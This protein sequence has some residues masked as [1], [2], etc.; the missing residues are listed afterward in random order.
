MP[1]NKNTCDDEPPKKKRKL[2]NDFKYFGESISHT[3]FKDTGWFGS[4]LLYNNFKYN[5]MIPLKKTG[6]FGECLIK[7]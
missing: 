6:F 2:N 7:K 1:L 3:T 5:K 4:S